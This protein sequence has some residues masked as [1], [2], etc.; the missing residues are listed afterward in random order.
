MVTAND[1]FFGRGGRLLARSQRDEELKFEFVTPFDPGSPSV[2]IASS[3]LHQEHFGET[4]AIS[5][6]SGDI[7]HSTCLGWGL[8]RIVLSLFHHHGTNPAKW[9]DDVRT[10]LWP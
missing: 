7:A 10:A 6:S 2:A 1:P 8:D 9:P 3:N 4:F 5:T